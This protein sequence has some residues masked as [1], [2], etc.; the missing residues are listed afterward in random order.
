MGVG[1]MWLSTMTVTMRGNQQVIVGWI[2]E[3][4]GGGKDS[5]RDGRAIELMKMAVAVMA[6]RRPDYLPFAPVVVEG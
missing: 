3:C 1:V 4:V 2:V 6:K 5:R